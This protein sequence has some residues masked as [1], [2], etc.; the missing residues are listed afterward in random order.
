M[1]VTRE[2]K[3]KDAPDMGAFNWADPFYLEDQLSDD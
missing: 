2:I 1:N 3:A